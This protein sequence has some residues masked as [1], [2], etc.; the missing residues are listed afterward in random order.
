MYDV[1]AIGDDLASHLA[2]AI[3]SSR[4]IRTAL[5]SE[6]GAA[7][8]CVAGDLLFQSNPLP[9]TG[10]GESQIFSSVLKSLGLS[11]KTNLLNPAY[12]IILPENRIDFFCG[13]EALVE[14][15]SRE[16]PESATDIQSFYDT[17]AET[18]S[19][20]GK[21]LLD[22]PFL[23]PRS[24]RDYPDL[25]KL[26]PSYLKSLSANLKFKKILAQNPALNKVMEAQ[27]VL[28]SFQQKY[29]S[30][31]FS[32]YIFSTPLR[33]I[34]EF[35]EGLQFLYSQL[36][37]TITDGGGLYLKDHEILSVKKGR[38]I[39]VTYMDQNSVASKIEAPKLLVS[40]KWQNMRLIL[41]RKK[42]F[43]F[44]DFMRPT[45]TSHS[46]FTLHLG[47]RPECIP[48][49]MARHVAVVGDVEK[50]IDDELNLIILESY[51]SQR[52][53]SSPSSRVPLSAT[54]FLP[55]NPDA[56]SKDR[57]NQ[58]ADSIIDRLDFF[59]P[60]LKESV[61]FIDIN[62]S[63][64]VSQKQRNIINARYQIKQSVLSRFSAKGNKT[65]F[66]NIYLTGASLFADA[67]FEGEILSAINAVASITEGRK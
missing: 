47:I 8:A 46:P 34:F 5:I 2:A 11:P 48:E 44:G 54:V 28:L 10:L 23:Q 15:L 53:P 50:K 51:I 16:F 58:V 39:E 22:H 65:R 7:D 67:G 35:P 25:I 57:L 45:R 60:F 13:K 1:I 27:R 4:G 6:T 41:D 3:A 63:I 33:G 26:I 29:Q 55:E 62:E 49:K 14:E 59:L 17:I 42:K 20:A 31:L 56:W 66:R 9:L 32:D 12:Q 38:M 43:S 18:S 61:E 21:W 30:V 37:N 40:T 52:E 36:I 24:L 64:T 19:K